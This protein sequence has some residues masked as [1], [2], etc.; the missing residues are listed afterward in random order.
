MFSE[1]ALERKN[2]VTDS[3]EHFRHGGKILD[4]SENIIME[5][6][7]KPY[8]G[9]IVRPYRLFVADFAVEIDNHR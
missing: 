1:R 5:I 6:E 3:D 7:R 9:S 2:D 4:T 8:L